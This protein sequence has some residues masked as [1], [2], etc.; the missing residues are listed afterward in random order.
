MDKFPSNSS[1]PAPAVRVKVSEPDALIPEE[2]AVEGGT[3][4]QLQQK[5]KRSRRIEA[6]QLGLLALFVALLIGSAVWWLTGRQ[7]DTANNPEGA[8]TG[9]SEG[10]SEVPAGAVALV[11]SSTP[12]SIA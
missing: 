7:G 9:T 11:N 2:G 1:P 10:V 5:P 3:P 8:S 4:E 12:I 6:M